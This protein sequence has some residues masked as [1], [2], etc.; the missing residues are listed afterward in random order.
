MNIIR[1]K[2]RRKMGKMEKRKDEEKAPRRWL[3]TGG[4]QPQ[5]KLQLPG[6]VKHGR[7]TSWSLLRK[8]SPA[9]T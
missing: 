1:E 8:H 2:K 6:A 3:Q 7:D 5:A 4:M 9:D